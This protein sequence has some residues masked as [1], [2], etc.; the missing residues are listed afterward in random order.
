MT[1]YKCLHRLVT[2]THTHKPNTIT[3]AA[4][5]LRID[6][7]AKYINLLLLTTLNDQVFAG[8]TRPFFLLNTKYYAIIAAKNML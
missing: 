7:V 6:N 4:H 1:V 2:H 3:L 5:V 8:G